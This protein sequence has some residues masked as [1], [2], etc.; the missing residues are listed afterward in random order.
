MAL[1]GGFMKQFLV[2]AFLTLGAFSS[3][4]KNIQPIENVGRI[5]V[6][7]PE[8]SSYPQAVQ[9]EYHR[10]FRTLSFRNK[11]IQPN[12]EYFVDAGEGCAELQITSNFIS[13]ERLCGTITPGQLTTLQY[14]A[15]H[16]EWDFANLKTDLGPASSLVVTNSQGTHIASASSALDTGYVAKNLYIGK[17][18]VYKSFFQIAN[19]SDRIDEKSFTVST[20]QTIDITPKD[21][22]EEL[23]IDFM[24]APE[25]FSLSHAQGFAYVIFRSRPHTDEGKTLLPGYFSYSGASIGN[26]VNYVSVSPEHGNTQSMK[27]FPIS[28]NELAMAASSW[29][30]EVVVN[31]TRWPLSFEKGKKQVV[32]IEIINVNDFQT[33]KPGVFTFA[34]KES[35]T[36]FPI[37]PVVSNWGDLTADYLPTS[38]SIL[39][40]PGYEYQFEFFLKDDLGK[41]LKQDTVILDLK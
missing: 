23:T 11:T 33:G 27:Y 7:L 38:R 10:T 6:Q 15:F 16:L 41:L 13:S 4:A 21:I 5:K 3:F 30:L 2:A 12:I 1:H 34:R 9:E 8:I 25:K 17:A 35:N 28:Q 22:R 31:E 37:L 24:N 19:T 20:S 14:S 32:P 18:G 40:L 39:L 29:V 36:L 26:V